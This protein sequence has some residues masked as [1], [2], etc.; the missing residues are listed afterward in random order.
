MEAAVSSV[1]RAPSDQGEIVGQ[2]APFKRKDI[3]ALRVPFRWRA[4]YE[5]QEPA[6][7][8]AIAWLLKAGVDRPLPRC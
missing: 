5:Y 3:R 4:E 2:K 6:C 8:A 7:C 1:H